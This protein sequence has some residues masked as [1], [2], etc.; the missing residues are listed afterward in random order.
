MLNDD[1]MAACGFLRMFMTRKVVGSL[2][3]VSRDSTKQMKMIA[4]QQNNF[5]KD[6]DK[7]YSSIK[8][9]IDTFDWMN[10]TEWI[11]MKLNIQ[12][13]KTSNTNEYQNL[14]VHI[15]F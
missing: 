11:W 2:W 7:R 13:V 14:S 10:L 4:E 5:W 6:F 15:L 12:S 9:V 3:E 8:L 1:G